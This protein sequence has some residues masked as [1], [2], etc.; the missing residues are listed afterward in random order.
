M[1]AAKFDGVLA[2]GDLRSIGK[3]QAAIANVR[4]QND[5]D[6]LFEY[7]FH[8]ERLIVM[9]AADAIEKITRRH[10]Q[11]LFKHKKKIMTLCR[12]A[13]DKELKWHLALMVVRLPLTGK[14]FLVVWDTLTAWATDKTNP[15]I[16]RVNAIQGLFEMT[17]RQRALEKDLSLTLLELEPENIPSINA[18]IRKIRKQF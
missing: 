6:G 16:V 11:Y 2:G 13:R 12:N 1:C 15:R 3:S 9:R 17:L 18:R 4:N 8:G 7:L 10:P 5:F 14:D